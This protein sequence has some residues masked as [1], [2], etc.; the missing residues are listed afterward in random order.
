MNGIQ[1]TWPSLKAI[2]SVGNRA[3][4][5]D[6]SQSTRPAWAFWAVRAT[7]TRIGASGDV[8]VSFDDDPMCMLTT[9]SV[10]WHAA[11]RGS[12]WPEWM[13]G[14]PSAAGFSENATA[15]EPFAAHR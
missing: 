9:V 3:S 15:C 1:P 10:S 14:R 5:P 12:Q 13:L 2:R 7:Q 6:D 4:R 8:V 11:H